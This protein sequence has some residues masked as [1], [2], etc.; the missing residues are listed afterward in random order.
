MGF[1]YLS[2]SVL[3]GS[4]LGQ[5]TYLDIGIVANFMQEETRNVISDFSLGTLSP[6]EIQAC[7]EIGDH[8]EQRG[9]ISAEGHPRP[10]SP[11]EWIADGRY[12][13][14]PR[15]DQQSCPPDP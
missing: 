12:M 14:E 13:Q 15:P 4:G 9:I 3:F 7:W 6:P 11:A 1:S 8:M 5:V 10:A 2:V